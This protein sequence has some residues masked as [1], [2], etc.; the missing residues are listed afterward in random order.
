MKCAH[1]QRRLLAAERPD[2][3]GADVHGHLAD[4]A[5]CRALQR[6]LLRLERD[7]PHLPVPPSSRRVAFVGQF[8]QQTPVDLPAVE[9]ALQ[10]LVRLRQPTPAKERGR[11]KL[12]LAFALAASLAFVA[13]GMWALNPGRFT[14]KDPTAPHR[15][16]L[17]VRVNTAQTPRARAEGVVQVADDVRDEVRKLAEA[18][19]ANGERM[20]VLAQFYRELMDEHLKKQVR[21]GL[22]GAGQRAWLD[23]IEAH[24]LATDSE[25]TFLAT[26][27][28]GTKAGESLK[29]I[30]LA[31][32]QT[33]AELN[34]LATE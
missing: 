34:A 5:S 10:P 31:A 26:M 8:L 20:A 2:H 15:V 12:A 19:D 25:F 13:F 33:S 1:V 29:D 4:C 22:P 14:P 7:I 6:R 32:R 27:R 23:G 18:K 28:P 16:R 21:A 3:V 24:L 9:T 17:E 11:R 30:A